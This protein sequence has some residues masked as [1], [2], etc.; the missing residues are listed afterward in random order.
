MSD[1]N[2]KPKAALDNAGRVWTYRVLEKKEKLSAWKAVS[3][4]E[5]NNFVDG[6]LKAESLFTPKNLAVCSVLIIGLIYL[7]YLLM[8][9]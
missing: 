8:A 5:W 3:E 6:V 7:A 2:A 1:F 4:Q 9:G